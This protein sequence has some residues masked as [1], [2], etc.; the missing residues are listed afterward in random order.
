MPSE[1]GDTQAVKGNG[2]SS[3]ININMNMKPV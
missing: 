2:K 1:A 3:E